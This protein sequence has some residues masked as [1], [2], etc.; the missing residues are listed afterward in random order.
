M[1]VF[2]YVELIEVVFFS[3]RKRLSIVKRCLFYVIGMIFGILVF[4]DEGDFMEK[5]DNVFGKDIEV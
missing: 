2:Y 5:F 1:C 4:E 3:K